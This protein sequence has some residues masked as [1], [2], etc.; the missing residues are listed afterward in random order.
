MSRDLSL[1]EGEWRDASSALVCGQLSFCSA[2]LR[3]FKKVSKHVTSLKLWTELSWHNHIRSI[4]SSVLTMDETTAAV[5]GEL[6]TSQ[7]PPLR[8]IHEI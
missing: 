4:S 6:G 3:K 5:I 1:S 8:V 2:W 7:I